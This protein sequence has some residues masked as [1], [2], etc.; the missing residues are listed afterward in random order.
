MTN[1]NAL[2]ALLRAAFAVPESGADFSTAGFLLRLKFR[3]TT[4]EELM[5]LH[6]KLRMSPPI[7]ADATSL[8]IAQ[9]LFVSSCLLLTWREVYKEDAERHRLIGRC[10][11][12]MGRVMRE[13]EVLGRA[14]S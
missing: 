5:L 3:E 8:L 7:G 14:D 9:H 2:L 12:E 4:K 6:E 1:E 11:E 13:K 10:V